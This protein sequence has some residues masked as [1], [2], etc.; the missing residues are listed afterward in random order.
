[1][2]EIDYIIKYKIESLKHFCQLQRNCLENLAIFNRFLYNMCLH[3]L[4][5]I[6]GNNL[7]I[8]ENYSNEHKN[9]F[10]RFMTENE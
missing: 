9:I 3:M 1:M 8:N 4:R 6:T 7:E 10:F 2:N 5:K